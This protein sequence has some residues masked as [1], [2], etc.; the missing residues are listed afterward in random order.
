MF[1]NNS[2]RNTRYLKLAVLSLA[3]WLGANLIAVQSANA[4]AIRADAGFLSSTLAANDDGSTGPVPFGFTV[5]FFGVTRT[6][7]WV[8]NN[9]NL[10]MDAP[11]STFTP[12]PLLS[13]SRE[14]LA[15]FFG[16]VDTSSE[17]SPVTYGTSTIGGQAAFGV[18]WVNVDYYISNAA[19][20]NRNSF[21]LVLVDRSDVAV[22]DFDFEFNID[23]V[24]W[25]TGQAGSSG[26]D[27]N[28]R[29]G[30]CARVGWSNGVAANSFEL[31]GSGVCGSFLDSGTPAVIPGSLAL[32]NHE[33]NSNLA[34]DSGGASTLGRY[35]FQVRNG[36]VITP[37]PPT[38]VL[39]PGSLALMFLGLGLCGL[40][41]R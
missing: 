36:V 37:P 17:G 9:G 18:N 31:P 19:H 5:N 39:E 4:V 27:G 21:Q 25:E 10:T 30:S 22:G 38:P 14:I 29:G 1:N 23:Q 6:G 20:T 35:M 16:D 40:A 3:T 33:L 7:G 2:I 12:F 26:G 41:R 13:T 32:F 28:G 34:I 11:L 15:P 24:Q 8:N